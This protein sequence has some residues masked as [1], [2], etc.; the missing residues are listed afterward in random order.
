MWDI[1]ECIAGNMTTAAALNADHL[2]F[3][4]TPLN[5]RSPAKHTLHIRLYMLVPQ[6]K[7]FIHIK[8]LS[9]NKSVYS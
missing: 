4:I 1:F 6:F 5:D 2:L 3:N 9:Y 8:C 7:S